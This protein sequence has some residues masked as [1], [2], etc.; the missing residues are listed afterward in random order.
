MIG[1]YKITS[2]S[3]KIYIGQ[4]VNIERRFNEYKKLYKSNVQLVLYRSFLKYGIL[5]HKFEIIEQCKLDELNTRER[6]WQEYYDVL[7]KNGLNCE[8]VKTDLKNKKVSTITKKQISDTL[9]LKYKSGEIIPPKLGKGLKYNIYNF[10]GDIIYNNIDM[11]EIVD[12]LNLS[13]RSV[14]NNILRKNRY[15]SKKKYII[16]PNNTNYISFIKNCIL[17]NKGYIIPIYQIF[18]DGTIKKCTS[19]QVQKIKNKILDNKDMI[20]YSKK[21]KSHYTFIGLINAVLERNF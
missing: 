17:I 10:K 21:N 5:N 8:Y 4:S 20:Y 3:N 9:K 12:K 16:V 1:I 15:L 2:P 18:E 6:Y 19:S 13:N 7:G 11:R 14:I